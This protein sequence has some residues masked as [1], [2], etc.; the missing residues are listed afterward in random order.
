[1]ETYA[2]VPYADI[3]P[4]PVAG[5]VF[6]V[7]FGAMFGDAGHGL[8]LLLAGLLLRL[9]HPARFARF[10][11]AWPFVVGAAIAAIF[12]GVLYGEFFGPTGVLPVL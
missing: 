6:V 8:L 7:M 1:M 11:A 12:F 4:S 10:H 2:T 3:D 5:V 9:G